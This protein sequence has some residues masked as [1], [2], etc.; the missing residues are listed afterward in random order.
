MVGKGEILY[1]SGEALM[2]VSPFRS[3]TAIWYAPMA[4]GVAVNVKVL[5]LD[6]L[7]KPR[8]ALDEMVKSLNTALV[9]PPT[10]IVQVMTLPK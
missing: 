4:P 5:P 2:A 8:T 9:V 7:E 6:P 3:E 10:V 1:E